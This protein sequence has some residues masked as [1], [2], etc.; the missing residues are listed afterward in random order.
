MVNY[1]SYSNK[2]SNHL[3]PSITLQSLYTQNTTYP[4]Q[5]R[6]YPKMKC[7]QI[8]LRVWW[9]VT[10]LPHL[11]EVTLRKGVWGPLKVRRSSEINGAKYCISRNFLALKMIPRKPNFH[12]QQVNH[13]AWIVRNRILSR[14]MQM[15]SGVKLD[16]E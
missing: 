9:R 4:N 1:S 14:A 2:T 12:E 16:L 11:A 3:L 7:T 5:G 6:S 13:L 8:C 15:C 10:T